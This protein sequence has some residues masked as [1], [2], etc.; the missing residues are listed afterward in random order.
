MTLL[1][2]R[3]TSGFALAG[4]LA[5]VAL[6]E[7]PAARAQPR[8]PGPQPFQPPQIMV[9]GGGT[10]FFRA[11]LDLA[12]IKPVRANDLNALQPG[13]DL[14]V[15]VFGN[16]SQWQRNDPTRW[17]RETVAAGGAALIVSDSPLT[18]Y[19]SDNDPLNAGRPLG[20]FS[21]ETVS[22][23]GFDNDRALRG[24]IDCPFAVPV[25]PDEVLPAQAQPG[26]VWGVFR[27]L[28][29]VATN[30][31]TFITLRQHRAEYRYPLARLPRGVRGD[32]GTRFLVPPL[33]ATGGD[34]APDADGP[35]YSFLA[36]ADSSIYIN[37]ML[38]EPGADNR[39]LA[40][41][42][43]EYLRG[44]NGERTRCVF[45]ENGR[46]IESFDQLRGAMAPPRPP[47]PPEAM[48]NVPQVM[49]K[50]QDKLV[51][52]IDAMADKFQT[53]DALHKMLVGAPGSERERNTAA[54][55][56]QGLLVPLSLAIGWFF[57]RGFFR[58]RNPQDAPPPP[59]TGAGAASTGP[60]GVFER[61]QKELVRR[62]NIYEPVKALLREFFVTVGAPA[63]A[64]PR[65]P[66]L[67]VSDEVRKPE[68]LRL[69]LRDLWRLAYGPPTTLTAQR[70]GEL[71][72]YFE[73]LKKAHADGKWR[74]VTDGT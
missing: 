70:W 21:G 59:N 43:V 60:P 4:L 57:L 6:A 74:F 13:P 65:M 14:I 22:M 10:E 26:R 53:Q 9:S 32:H 17:A 63:D 5:A 73:R 46:V 24:L 56:V 18:I 68:S 36:V 23:G 67:D 3:R 40:Y 34:G 72:P 71:E 64:G 52:M 27:G 29:K 50:N 8:P 19:E 51:E 58:V 33:L 48:P 66:T 11:L 2:F 38:L 69:A 44:P 61:R 42:T 41:R 28:D 15:V 30:Q 25:S 20:T 16:P 31:P 37:Q 49:R 47:V 55:W 45:F 12:D 62:N 7:P 54:G 39:K 1:T 35:G